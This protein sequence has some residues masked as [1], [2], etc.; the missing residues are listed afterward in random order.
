MDSANF[1]VPAW[2]HYTLPRRGQV[3]ALQH[4]FVDIFQGEYTF[5]DRQR[6]NM[7]LDLGEE[8]TPGDE[9]SSASESDSEYTLPGGGQSRYRSEFHEYDLRPRV[10]RLPL[11][12]ITP[13]AEGVTVADLDALGFRRVTWDDPRVFADLDDRVVCVF[14]GPPVQRTA[15]EATI[16][17]ASQIMRVASL[18][19]DCARLPADSIRSGITYDTTLKRPRNIERM[20]NHNLQ[21]MV[22]LAALR[23]TPAIQEITSFQNAALKQAAPRLWRDARRVI[24]AVVNNDQTL[25]LPMRLANEGPHQP[26][27]FS[28]LE[29]RF[30]VAASVPRTERGDHPPAFRAITSVGQYPYH[31]GKLILWQHRIVLDFPPGSTFIFP[32]GV[33][34]YSF[35]EVEKPGWQMIVT[36][37]CSA[38]LHGF[39]ANGFDDRYV[40]EPR[41]PTRQ[42]AVA[43]RVKRAREAVA[44]YPTVSEFDA[45]QAVY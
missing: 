5:L 15:W 16:R 42:A 20:Q 14:I 13:T 7:R 24:D 9:S 21:N 44:L 35:T 1:R 39:V 18:Q 6:R 22:V 23:Y 3:V 34:G 12:D 36:Q 27:A 11:A 33:V 4:S 38:G 8:L 30:S 32:A 31:E 43:D 40:R 37:S 19:L 25:N 41:F 10:R 2:S 26:S 28:E 17:S 29:Y 45:E